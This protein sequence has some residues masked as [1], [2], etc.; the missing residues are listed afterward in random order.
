MM[1]PAAM[2]ERVRDIAFWERVTVAALVEQGL[3]VVLTKKERENGGPY[4]KRNGELKT[5]RPEGVKKLQRR[6]P[7]MKRGLLK[8]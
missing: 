2:V 1:L 5:G 4:E 6:E 7:G 8:G 3:N